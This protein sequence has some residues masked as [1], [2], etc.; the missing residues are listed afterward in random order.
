MQY[1]RSYTF[2]HFSNFPVIF[3]SLTSRKMNQ[4]TTDS[5]FYQLY[6]KHI[7]VYTVKD[8]T[9]KKDFKFFSVW[10]NKIKYIT[11]MSAK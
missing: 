3:Q 8:V 4:I 10:Y 5:N 7:T 2:P 6:Y 11:L 9:W 1:Q